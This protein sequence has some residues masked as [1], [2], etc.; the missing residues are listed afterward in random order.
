MLNICME[1]DLYL[2]IMVLFVG[3]V[4]IFLLSVIL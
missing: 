3:I 1:I 2:Q 4:Y